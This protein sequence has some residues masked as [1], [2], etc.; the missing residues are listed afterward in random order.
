[1]FAYPNILYLTNILKRPIPD[2]RKTLCI[3]YRKNSNSNLEYQTK[4]FLDRLKSGQLLKMITFKVDDRSDHPFVWRLTLV[5]ELLL[6]S[7]LFL[8]IYVRDHQ[9]W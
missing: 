7:S 9:I 8:L 1:M 4:D 2:R 3:K 6:S 5:K